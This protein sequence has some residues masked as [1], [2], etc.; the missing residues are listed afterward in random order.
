MKPQLWQ[1][2]VKAGRFIVF[3]NVTDGLSALHE[4]QVDEISVLIQ[5]HLLSLS[6]ELHYCFADLGDLDRQ[7]IR[8]PL[9]MDPRSLPDELQDKFVIL[10][11]DLNV[12]DAFE[13]LSL[14][15]F[16]HTQLWLAT[17][18]SRHFQH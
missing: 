2:K 11:N 18:V 16:C 9:K 7:L 15:S 1:E 6:Q 8:N 12:R 13:S 17:S 3:E 4:K 5:D 10:V 14:T